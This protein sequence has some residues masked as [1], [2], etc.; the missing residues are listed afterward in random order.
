MKLE[1]LYDLINEAIDNAFRDEKYDLDFYTCLQATNCKRN[2]I[3]EFIDSNL[4]VAIKH[5][6]EEL[7]LYIVGGEQYVFIQES[8]DWMGKHRAQKT[9][10]YLNQIIE[11][12]KRYEKSKRPGRKPKA[13]ANK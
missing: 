8:Y 6:I 9:K 2:I 4:G 1:E 5:Q 11:D 3:K 7:H 13:S 10:N 12:A